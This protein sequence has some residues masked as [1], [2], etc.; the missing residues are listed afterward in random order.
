MRLR[1]T[2]CD[3]EPARRRDLGLGRVLQPG[4]RRRPGR[5]RIEKPSSLRNPARSAREEA[6]VWPEEV[7]EIFTTDRAD[8]FRIIASRAQPGD[9][10]QWIGSPDT[11]FWVEISD[12]GR[13]EAPPRPLTRDQLASIDRLGFRKESDTNFARTFE[14]A[15]ESLPHIVRRDHGSVCGRRRRGT[16]VPQD[17][18]ASGGGSQHGRD[19]RTVRRCEPAR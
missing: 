9:Y 18:S 13:N 11:R 12:P 2:W 5:G 15:E 4:P 16:E 3:R 10:I 14:F 17:W 6:L 7:R 19:R 8:A 1:R